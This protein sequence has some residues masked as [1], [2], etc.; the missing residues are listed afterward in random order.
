L[1]ARATALLALL[2]TGCATLPVAPPLATHEVL[3]G[4][5]DGYHGVLPPEVFAADCPAM[6]RSPQLSA[7]ALA[8]FLVASP[9][10]TLALVEAPDADLA[11]AL[12]RERPAALELGN[13][14]ELAPR[15][16][17]PEQYSTWTALALGRL[18]DAEYRGVVVL[19]G[20]YALTDETKRAIK[21]GIGRCADA[22]VACRVGVHLYDAS[23]EDLAWLRALDWPVWVTEVGYPTRCDP[24]RVAEQRVWVALQLT[25]FATVPRLERAFIY[26][27]ADGGGCSDL[28]TFGVG[29]KPAAELLT[30]RSR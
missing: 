22:G 10:D 3:V 6:I 18:R 5:N 7:A 28:E 1:T 13:E 15:E 30:R 16:L 20:V 19:G 27:R 11:E 24:S 21:L 26:Q 12:A 29:G 25:R 2:A 8:A 9:C 14:L 17:T 4:I 23:D